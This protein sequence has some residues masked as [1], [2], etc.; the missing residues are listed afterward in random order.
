MRDAASRFVW[1]V[2]WLWWTCS[3]R[4]LC[5]SQKLSEA[6]NDTTHD[7]HHHDMRDMTVIGRSREHPTNLHQTHQTDRQPAATLATFREIIRTVVD[8]RHGCTRRAVP[9]GP[10]CMRGSAAHDSANVEVRHA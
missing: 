7:I 10:I 9:P 5:L 1:W 2:W 3:G 4:N 8:G 6:W